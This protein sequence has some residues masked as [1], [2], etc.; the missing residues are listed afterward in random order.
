VDQNGFK[1]EI[2]SVS[3]FALAFPI[4]ALVRTKDGR[5]S[6]MAF[7][8]EGKSRRGPSIYLTNKSP[9]HMTITT[10]DAASPPDGPAFPP[11]PPPKAPAAAGGG[12]TIQEDH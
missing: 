1:A 12:W 11:P 3:P 6:P 4:T 2:V 9:S 7:D 5:R 8:R 10:T